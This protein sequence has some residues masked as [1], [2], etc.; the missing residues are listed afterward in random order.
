MV[1][2]QRSRPPRSRQKLWAELAQAQAEKLSPMEWWRLRQQQQPERQQ[3]EQ[4]RQRQKQQERQLAAGDK[5]LERLQMKNKGLVGT[6]EEIAKNKERRMK[7]AEKRS[8]KRQFHQLLHGIV[9]RA[10]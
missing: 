3:Q 4:E 6:P 10:R 5:V 1:G 7:D 2:P 8:K 9:N